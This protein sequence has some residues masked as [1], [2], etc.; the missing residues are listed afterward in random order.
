MASTIR[1]R[2]LVALD[3]ELKS[4]IAEKF[5]AGLRERIIGQE[6]AVRSVTSLYQ[7]FQADLTSMNRP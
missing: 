3:P 7:V 1:K 2:K 4:P 6:R 5:E